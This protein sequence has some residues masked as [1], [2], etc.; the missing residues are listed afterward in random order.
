M[1]KGT[2]FDGINGMTDS[3]LY[4]YRNDNGFDLEFLFCP[5][6]SILPRL[7]GQ[8]CKQ[9][10]GPGKKLRRQNDMPQQVGGLRL[11]G[12][13][14]ATTPSCWKKLKPGAEKFQWPTTKITAVL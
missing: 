8:T 7:P 13:F 5:P 10:L 3:G 2:G 11:N 4:R 9:A 12:V 14:A 1:T 6:G